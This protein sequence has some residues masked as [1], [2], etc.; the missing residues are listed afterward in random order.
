[1]SSVA[2]ADLN[3]QTQAGCP[4]LSPSVLDSR[5]G[6]IVD[7]RSPHFSA[8]CCSDCFLH[9]PFS[10]CSGSRCRSFNDISTW[11]VNIPTMC[12]KY[13]NF[14]CLT[15]P[16]RLIC[17]SNNN[18]NNNNRISIALYGRNVRGADFCERGYWRQRAEFGDP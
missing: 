7:N 10:T 4:V 2:S 8:T 16:I 13:C 3:K 17:N 1:M 18:N 11:H 15:V 14:L 6:C 5:V 9:E 12:P